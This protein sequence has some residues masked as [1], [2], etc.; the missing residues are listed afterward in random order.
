MG[1]NS[2]HHAFLI[3]LS[4]QQNVHQDHYDELLAY[5]KEYSIYYGIKAEDCRG[6]GKVHLH[7]IHIRDFETQRPYDKDRKVDKYGPRRTG[8]TADHIK[9]NCPKINTACRTSWSLR[10]DALTSSYYIE[11]LNKE[12][13]M[14]VNNFP[15][16]HC[17]MAQYYSIKEDRISDPEVTADAKQYNK[18]VED[19]V[20][21]ALDPPT[22]SSCRRFYRVLSND[23]KEK[24]R[25]LDDGTKNCPLR[26]KALKLFHDMTS[27]CFSD[28]EEE[29]P[30]KKIDTKKMAQ[31]KYTPGNLTSQLH[32]EIFGTDSNV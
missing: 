21:W 11:Y 28:D 31:K 27:Y 26:K 12:T 10:V 7:A 17:M 29:P 23:K 22:L 2:D 18:F 6:E 1:K 3:T 30:P 5:L 15:A 14:D 16:D 9:L 8:S 20:W 25:L 19:G 32:K 4:I 13:F 24:R